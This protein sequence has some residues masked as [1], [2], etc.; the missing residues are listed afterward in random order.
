MTATCSTAELPTPT[1]LTKRRPVFWNGNTSFSIYAEMSKQLVEMGWM[2]DNRPSAI[3]LCSVVL[4]DRF[5]IP[6]HVLRAHRRAPS[7][8]RVWVNYFKGS[9]RLTLKAPMAAALSPIDSGSPPSWLPQTF[10]LCSDPTKKGVKDQRD[11]L[12]AMFA[13]HRLWIAKPS[14]GCKGAD[15]FVAESL[16]DILDHVDKH[17]AVFVVQHYIERPLLVRGLRKFDIRVWALLVDPYRMYMYSE[18]SCRTA[19][20][21]FTTGDL[22]NK[23]VHLTNHCLQEGADAFGTFEEDNEIMLT[24]LFPHVVDQLSVVGRSRCC[25]SEDDEPEPQL[26]DQVVTSQMA[27]IIRQTLEC[28]REE[29]EVLDSD[30]YRCFQF[31]GYDFIVD[32]DLCVSLLEINGSPGAAQ[33]LLPQIVKGIIDVVIGPSNA[34]PE[35]CDNI[36]A[37]QQSLWRVI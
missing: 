2:C 17:K 3:T 5:T 31:F 10:V 37:D 19:S 15:V 18:G 21:P 32:E 13:S 36:T 14:S 23:L 9:H 29:I 22:S 1:G 34:S 16:S 35:R 27:S 11:A 26:F 33:R 20:V 30:P 25:R 28:V 4:G 12:G 8:P 7:E 6:Y 24:Q